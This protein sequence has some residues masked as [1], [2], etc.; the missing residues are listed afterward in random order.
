VILLLKG[1]TKRVLYV[2]DEE[3]YSETLGCCPR[4]EVI[5]TLHTHLA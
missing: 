5:H 2:V 4:C 3:G 1:A